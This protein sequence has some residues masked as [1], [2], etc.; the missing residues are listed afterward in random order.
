MKEIT[1]VRIIET[2]CNVLALTPYRL[3][4]CT[5]KSHNFRSI[6]HHSHHLYGT[7]EISTHDGLLPR[8]SVVTD[9]SFESIL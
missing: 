7:L 6:Y 1:T 2:Q 4:I 3:D 5:Q 9:D 8:S